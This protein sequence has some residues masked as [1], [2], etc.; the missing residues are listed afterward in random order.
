MSRRCPE[1]TSIR[2]SMVDCAIQNIS[3]QRIA[4]KSCVACISCITMRKQLIS[5]DHGLGICAQL[6]P[7]FAASHFDIRVSSLSGKD[8]VGRSRCF[9]SGVRGG[10]GGSGGEESFGGNSKV[11]IRP[12]MPMKARWLLDINLP[13]K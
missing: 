3:T 6:V 13:Q 10:H 9:G 7:A 8:D 4:V 2:L 11:Y 5:A 1:R 12:W